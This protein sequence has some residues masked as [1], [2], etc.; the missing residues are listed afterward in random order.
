MRSTTGDSAAGFPTSIVI[1]LTVAALGCS[2]KP[3]SATDYVARLSTAR[4][5]KDA[6]LSRSSEPVPDAMKRVLLPLAYYPVNPGYDVPAVMNP[7]D[8]APAGPMVY[9][10]GAIRNVRQVGKLNF[11]LNGKQLELAAF[12]EV[13]APED[14]LFV[15]FAD[16]TNG[17]ETYN[18][19]RLLD[20]PRTAT[21]LYDLDFN[22]AYNP[23]CY[24]SPTY[25]CPLPP[26]ENRMAIAVTAG[27]R[28]KAK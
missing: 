24:Y 18:S 26:K 10:D 15:P 21:G 16:L 28:V 14:S 2:S 1:A 8:D 20:V 22:R 25:S 9:S 27:E 7:T 12:V 3:P 4:A 5:E 19:G 13:G 23:S 11:V 6:A 17:T